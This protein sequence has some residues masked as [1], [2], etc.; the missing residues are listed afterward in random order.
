MLI[1]QT[2]LILADI[3][4]LIVAIRRLINL[5]STFLTKEKYSLTRYPFHPTVLK[6]QTTEAICHLLYTSNLETLRKHAGP[7][8]VW[9]N[10]IA[11]KPENDRQLMRQINSYL[12]SMRNLLPDPARIE[13]M[14]ALAYRQREQLL[15]FLLP[16]PVLLGIACLL[17]RNDEVGWTG[18]ATGLLSAVGLTIAYFF[19]A[20]NCHKRISE[21]TGFFYS[22]LP[23]PVNGTTED[24]VRTLQN[25]LHNFRQG[26]AEDISRLLEANRDQ[27]TAIEQVQR[28]QVDAINRES[29]MLE[30]ISRMDFPQ[31]VR[32]NTDVLQQLKATIDNFG[33]FTHLSESL[34]ALLGTMEHLT[35]QI[36]T[37]L[38][39]TADI[40][41][42][43]SS[44][45]KTVERNAQLQEFLSAHTS[46]LADRK[47]LINA[48]VGGIDEALSGSLK[49]LQRHL[50]EQV[51]SIRTITLHEQELVSDM[52]HKG[53]LRFE[54]L[55]LLDGVIREMTLIRKPLQQ[56]E[57]ALPKIIMAL[58]STNK[59]II[60]LRA[61]MEKKRFF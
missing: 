23:R 39:R 3:T 33:L 12:I 46:A 11:H 17:F 10:I 54:K 26:M 40:S 53:N 4:L 37:G 20:E 9:L 61:V 5:G 47:N 38:E 32:F 2:L 42:I 59:E 1:L 18:L 44:I 31:I 24:A 16:M 58:E 14:I 45:Q 28:E 49:E 27:L 29:G 8:P 52:I 41:S 51:T 60:S 48:T 15:R 55:E 7:Q 22:V 25:E 56:Q 30:K 43:A 6:D 36:N 13:G 19:V 50:Q 57:S 34:G 35:Q 21:L